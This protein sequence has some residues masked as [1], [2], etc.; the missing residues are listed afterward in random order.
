MKLTVE[1]SMKK[2]PSSQSMEFC[3]RHSID[4]YTSCDTDCTECVS[5][6]YAHKGQR[7]HFCKPASKNRS[8]RHAELRYIASQVHRKSQL[9]HHRTSSFYNGIE[10]ELH[11]KSAAVRLFP[12]D[13]ADSF[14]LLCRRVYPPL[15]PPFLVVFQH[16]PPICNRKRDAQLF[17]SFCDLGDEFAPALWKNDAIIFRCASNLHNREILCE[18]DLHGHLDKYFAQPGIQG[19]IPLF[20]DRCL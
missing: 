16:Q 19:H 20:V 5:S 13:D 7:L 15:A 17:Q 14:R 6:F 12:A 8:R 1:I 11:R 10:Q 18:S 3:C 2:S 4:P 9:S